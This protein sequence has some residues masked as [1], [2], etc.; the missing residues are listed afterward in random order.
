MCIWW[1]LTKYLEHIP[2]KEH[3]HPTCGFREDFEI[4]ASE[5]IGRSS[6]VEFLNQ[7]KNM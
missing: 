6:H 2:T 3:V 1:F 4:S 7:M 5:R